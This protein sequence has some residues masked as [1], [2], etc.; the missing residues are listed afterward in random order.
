MASPDQTQ[1][2]LSEAELHKMLTLVKEADSVELKL[3]IPDSNQR[4]AVQALGMDPL[5]AEIRQVFFF[6]TPALALNRAGV[7]VRARRVQAKGDDSVVKLRPVVPSELPASLRKSKSFGVE[8]DAMPGGFVCSGSLKG[9]PG[10]D[11]R[12]VVTGG[13]RLSKLF[14]KEQRAFYTEHAPPGIELDALSVLGPINLL[15]LKFAPKGYGRRLVAEL[16]LYPDGSRILELSTKCAPKDAVEVVARLAGVPR[17]A[18][19][20]PERRAADQDPHGTRLLRQGARRRPVG[21][22]G[23]R[24]GRLPCSPPDSW[25][26]AYPIRGVPDRHD[27]PPVHVLPASDLG[28]VRIPPAR[29]ERIPVSEEQR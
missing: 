17:E 7:V 25:R 22:F 28:L 27:P 12:R 2:Q 13:K 29:P 6:D 9:V 19:C 1:L 20:R 15:K 3:T 23:E 14:S 21:H 4:S 18:R 26:W 8:V 24:S 16:W 5:D 10:A 11:V